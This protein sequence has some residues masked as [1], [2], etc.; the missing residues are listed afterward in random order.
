MGLVE[1]IRTALLSFNAV[2]ALVGTGSSARIYPDAFDE[3]ATLPAILVEIDDE[4]PQN[5]LDGRGGLRIGTATI[6]CRAATRQG[7][8]AL[9]LA[10][11]GNGANPQTGLRTY[12]GSGWD[13]DTVN[14]IAT[15]A[16]P[17]GYG[18]QK[19]YWDTVIELG[20]SATEVT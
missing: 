15:A 12:V 14:S 11:L 20:T 4:E 17:K 1:N 3:Q 7:A 16:S 10:V 19:Q 13:V 9:A 8:E 6:T 2:T 5:S 18:T